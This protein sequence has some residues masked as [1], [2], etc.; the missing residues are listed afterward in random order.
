AGDNLRDL[1]N[2]RV[3]PK[4]KIQSTKHIKPVRMQIRSLVCRSSIHI[5]LYHGDRKP[6]S[7]MGE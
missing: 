2:I 7:S 5:A 3:L 6:E 1:Q 4:N